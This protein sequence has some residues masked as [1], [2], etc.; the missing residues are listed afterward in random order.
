LLALSTE[1]PTAVQ[2]VADVHDTPKKALDDWPDGSGVDWIDHR[3]PSHRS[4]NVTP[5]PALLTDEPTA[6]HAVTAV[7]DT[8]DRPT[9]AKVRPGTR[10]I[11]QLGLPAAAEAPVT[12]P[13]KPTVKTGKPNETI[14]TAT[15]IR[16]RYRCLV[17]WRDRR[18]PTS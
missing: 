18:S 13:A 8:A 6:V 5:T 1:Y 17:A 2:A 10:W 14:A 3:V 12:L 16:N 9:L 4:A 15:D 11:A 7:Q